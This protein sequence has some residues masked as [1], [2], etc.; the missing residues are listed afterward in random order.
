[1][2]ARTRASAVVLVTALGTA[3]AT[4]V[5]PA[6]TSAQGTPAHSTRV[7]ASG[8]DGPFGLQAIRHHGF[9]VAENVTGEVTKVDRHGHKRVIIRRAGGVAGVAAGHARVY[10]VL[11][12]PDETG[13]VPPG[14]KYPPGALLRSRYDGSRVKVI[15]NLTKYELRHNPDGQVQFVDGHPVDSLSNPF[16]LNK[17][18]LGLLVA[19][20]GANDV[21]RVNPKT[22]HVST[23]F[24][25]PTV[26]DVPACKGPDANANP[27]TKGCDPVPTGVD[28]RGGSVYVSTLGAERPRA[29]RIYRLDARTGRVQRV[30]RNFT[31]LTGIAVAR[32]GT[33]YVSEVFY[34]APEGEPGPGF[35]PSTVGRITKIRHGRR[36]HAQVTMPTGLEIKRGKLYAS[37]WSVANF[38][39]IDHAGKIERV[40]QS[41]FH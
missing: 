39:G 3:G 33:I 27:G 35:D 25:P 4:A 7:V 20:G 37:T 12:G 8:L 41:A 21:L 31:G 6:A 29:A 2:H 1:M 38:L 24:V 40:K 28:V 13:G 15:A 11:G 23:F 19:D 10:A 22:G 32:N 36:T 26:K 18:R 14:S 17:S 9:L 5:T 30:W 16:S 34:G